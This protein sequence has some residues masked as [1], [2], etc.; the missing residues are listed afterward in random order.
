MIEILN[1]FRPKAKI[2]AEQML[3]M[4]EKSGASKHRKQMIIQS[5]SEDEWRQDR[6]EWSDWMSQMKA[7]SYQMYATPQERKRHGK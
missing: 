1:S 3:A 2:K 6:S 5:I 7:K 4:A